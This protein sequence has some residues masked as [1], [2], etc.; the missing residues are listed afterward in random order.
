MISALD[1]LGTNKGKILLLLKGGSLKMTDLKKVITSYDVLRYAILEL[2]SAGLVIRKETFDDKRRIIVSLTQSGEKLAEQL[3][4]AELA[5]QGRLTRSFF[6]NPQ[7]I[8][9]F[10]GKVGRATV[11]EIKNEIPDS[12]DDVKELEGMKILRSEVDNGAYPS[13]QWIMLTEKGTGICEDAKRM[14]EKLKR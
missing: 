12:Y 6:S 4:N 2:E 5:A 11:Q 1:L 3:K 14:E 13:Q 8:I 10:L 7:Q 9:L